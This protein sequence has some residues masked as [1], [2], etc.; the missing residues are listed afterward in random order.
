MAL[1]NTFIIDP[2]GKVAKVFEGVKPAAHSQEVLA[3]LSQL[4][5]R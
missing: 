4:Q 5:R 3:A 2:G 1:R